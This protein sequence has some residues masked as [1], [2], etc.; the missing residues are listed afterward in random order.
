MNPDYRTRAS[1]EQTVRAL[2]T[3]AAEARAPVEARW[4]L[5]TDYYEGRHHTQE[6][7]AGS[8]RDAGLPWIA[9][10]S[11]DIYLHVESQ[12]RTMLPDFTFRGRD[13]DGDDERARA[14]EYLVRYVTEQQGLADQT[15][16][17]ER[18]CLL[19]GTAVWKVFWDGED[20][21]VTSVDPRALYPDPAASRLEDCEYVDY[22]YRLPRRAAVRLYGD[23]LEALGIDAQTLSGALPFEED[24]DGDTLAV[25]EHWYRSDGGRVACSILVGER[26]ARHIP[27]YWRVTGCGLLPFVLQYRVA[28]DELWGHSDLEP[29]LPLVDAVDR[30]LAAAQLQSAFTGSDVILAEHDA[31]AQNPEIRPGAIWELR[32]G[33]I[34]KIRRLGGLG[35]AGNRLAMIEMLRGMIRDAV[36]NY[37]AQ[38][39]DQ[40]ARTLSATGLAL[41]LER[42]D[43]RRASKKA[44][45]LRAY[46]RLFRLIDWTVLEFYDDARVVRLGSAVPGEAPRVYRFSR[47][48]LRGR[49]GYFPVIDCTVTA[50]DAMENSRAFTLSSLE[51]LLGHSVT[52]ENYPLVL[53]ALRTLD[54]EGAEEL[55]RYFERLFEDGAASGEE[56]SADAAEKKGETT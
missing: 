53:T 8:C 49:D 55:R 47:A 2:L 48:A 37:D 15:P 27:D 33:A 4:N 51:T 3:A 9:A 56:A 43:L 20:V 21:R 1:R 52:R 41:M 18:R 11:P 16:V 31:F 19:C 54:L 42:A 50:A 10:C 13:A 30:E 23:E 44:E 36:G 46:A 22:V 26:E 12:V 5:V 40:S 25:V 6:E 24:T 38:L 32:P 29:A 14:R 7:I 17:H 34:D 35:D 28:G 39:D 45:C